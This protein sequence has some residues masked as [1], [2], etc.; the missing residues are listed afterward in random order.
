MTMRQL[1]LN[2]ESRELLLALI[3]LNLRV[4]IYRLYFNGILMNNGLYISSKQ[5]KACI[6]FVSV[7][8][9]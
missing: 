8:R 3:G 4:D 2:N 6:A 9:K 1:L 5:I 7:E